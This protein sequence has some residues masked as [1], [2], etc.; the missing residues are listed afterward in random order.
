VILVERKVGFIKVSDVEVANE[1][2][3]L[4]VARKKKMIEESGE[5]HVA[6]VQRS[7][8]SPAAL[9]MPGFAE[10]YEQSEPV[11][12]MQL[13]FVGRKIHEYQQPLVPM[14]SPSSAISPP[15]TIPS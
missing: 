9:L 8:Q 12:L 1:G 7:G 4:V 6:E 3:E 13:K 5:L 11:A 10:R 14:H 15:I 2:L